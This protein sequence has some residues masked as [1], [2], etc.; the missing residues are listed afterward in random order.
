VVEG[1]GPLTKNHFCHKNDKFGLILTQFLTDRKHGQSL[2]TFGHGFHGSIA[3]RS[4]QMQCNKYPLIHGHAKRGRS[5]ITPEYATVPRHRPLL[6][7]PP[8][9]ERNMA[10]SFCLSVCSFVR[11]F[12][13]CQGVLMTAGAYRTDLLLYIQS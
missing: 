12:V 2:E 5:H 9:A 3:K 4:L 7:P 1:A 13:C 10:M 6:S 8:V 11:S